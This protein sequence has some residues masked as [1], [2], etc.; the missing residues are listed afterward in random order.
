VPS[1]QGRR[2]LLRALSDDAVPAVRE[3]AGWALARAHG[4]EPATRR[5][6]DAARAREPDAGVRSDLERDLDDL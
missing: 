1:E 2:A 6:L 4:D 5:A 3:A